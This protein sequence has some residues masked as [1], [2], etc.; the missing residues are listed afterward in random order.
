MKSKTFLP[1]SFVFAIAILT[2]RCSNSVNEPS[3]GKITHLSFSDMGCVNSG[4]LA[5]INS[6]PEVAWQYASGILRVEIIFHTLCSAEIKDSLI[7]GNSLTYSF[8]K[9]Y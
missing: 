9:R 4:S 3:D 6:D 5:K 8:S 2:M 7:L 1:L